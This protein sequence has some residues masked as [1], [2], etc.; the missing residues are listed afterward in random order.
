MEICTYQ[1]HEFT[2]LHGRV[3]LLTPG[4]ARRHLGPEQVARGEVSEVIL[5][6]DPLALSS[7]SRAGTTFKHKKLLITCTWTPNWKLKTY[8]RSKWWELQIP[9]GGWCRSASFQSELPEINFCSSKSGAQFF[10]FI[11][12]LHWRTKILGFLK[13]SIATDKHTKWSDFF[14]KF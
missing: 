2:E 5:G 3:Q 6:H 4:R 10:Y 1:G 7:L 14:V 8:P 9:S 11:Y 13:V 12:N